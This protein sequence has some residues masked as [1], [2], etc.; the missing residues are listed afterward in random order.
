MKAY[1]QSLVA[2]EC[3]FYLAVFLL[4]VSWVQANIMTESSH[5][6]QECNRNS[7][8]NRLYNGLPKVFG[9]IIVLIYTLVRSWWSQFRVMAA[10]HCYSWWRWW[11]NTM[12]VTLIDYDC[13]H[14]CD[15]FNVVW[16]PLSH[17]YNF[18]HQSPYLSDGL[19]S[20]V[21]EWHPGS[22]CT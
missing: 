20:V 17:K 14:G 22:L 15:S 5:R 11:S 3:R 18:Y 16:S 19:W 6:F 21:I 10:R 12:W 2:A 8:H 7:G 1:P 9:F 13:A 4:A